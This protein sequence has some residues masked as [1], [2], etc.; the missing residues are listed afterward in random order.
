[1]INKATLIGNLGSDPEIRNLESGAKVAKFS[2]ATS[3]NYQDKSGEWQKLTEW[4]NIVAWRYLADKA[5]SSL[6][7]GSLVYV[8]GKIST[9]KWQ[10]QNGADRYS[11]DIVARIIR[12]LEKRES[13][14]SGYTNNFPTASDELPT[15]NMNT[16]PKAVM[17]DPTPTTNATPT[18]P[19]NKIDTPAVDDLP[20]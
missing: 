8:E 4:H 15:T 7:K 16:S 19:S 18:A 6:K 10:D 2:I 1:M 9:R 17:P 13:T 11:T 12:P 5:E 14:G 20:F 3:E